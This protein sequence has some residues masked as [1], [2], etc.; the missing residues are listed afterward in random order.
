MNAFSNMTLGYETISSYSV[1]VPSF[2]DRFAPL[3]E[4]VDGHFLPTLCFFLGFC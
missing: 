3:L 1:V 2:Y 4:G